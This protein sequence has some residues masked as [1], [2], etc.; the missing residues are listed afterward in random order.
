MQ[1][2]GPYPKL[3]E[4]RQYD[5][6]F[7]GRGGQTGSNAGHCPAC[8]APTLNCFFFFWG[9]GGGRTPVPAALNITLSRQCSAY[10]C[11]WFA[12]HF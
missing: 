5:F 2:S 11:K 6:P 7:V 3:R 1:Y 12:R 10:S 9:G 8:A 4:G